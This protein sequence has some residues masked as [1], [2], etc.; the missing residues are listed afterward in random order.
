MRLVNVGGAPGR[1][2]AVVPGAVR[3]VQAAHRRQGLAGDAD[4]RLVLGVPDDDAGVVPPLLHPLGVL[5]DERL[6]LVAVVLAERP[7]GELVLHDQALF[8]GNAVPQFGRESDAVPARV[9]VHAAEGADEVA[10]PFLPPRQVAALRVLEESVDAY[11]RSAQHVGLAVEHGQSGPGVEAE[12]SH[13]ETG[14]QHVGAGVRLQFVEERV[15][16]RPEAA[17]LDGDSQVDRAFGAGGQVGRRGL[18]SADLAPA[19]DFAH[20]KAHRRPGCR[21]GVLQQRHHAH[22]LAFDVGHGL[23]ADNVR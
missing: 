23:H 11:I 8:V 3:E 2:P 1:A 19:L 7:D 22:G 16:R 14:A 6:D 18:G 10:D 17:I 4:R 13:A 12:G 20:R 15:L 9:P 5:L 21:A